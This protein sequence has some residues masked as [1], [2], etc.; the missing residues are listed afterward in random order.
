M[1]CFPPNAT[2]C[3][4]CFAKNSCILSILDDFLSTQIFIF[5]DKNAFINKTPNISLMLLYNHG[6]KS[7][8]K[9]SLLP[10]YVIFATVLFFMCFSSCV[11]YFIQMSE[12]VF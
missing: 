7:I 12:N 5:F 11:Q 2:V 6:S 10:E 3:K 9:F 4:I 8:V 1:L